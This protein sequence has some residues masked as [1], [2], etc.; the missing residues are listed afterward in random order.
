M[1]KNTLPDKSGNPESLKK[2]IATVRNLFNKCAHSWRGFA[3]NVLQVVFDLSIKEKTFRS[4]V[5]T[6]SLKDIFT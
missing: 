4:K 6:S 5:L 2:L 3:D 1:L